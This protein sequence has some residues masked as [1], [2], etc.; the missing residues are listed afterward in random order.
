VALQIPLPGIS[1]GPQTQIKTQT[2]STM[3]R[4]TPQETTITTMTRMNLATIKHIDSEKKKENNEQ[5]L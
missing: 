1:T 4:I 5:W 3:E 2:T